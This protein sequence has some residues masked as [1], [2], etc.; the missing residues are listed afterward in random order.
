MTFALE[1]CLHEVVFEGDAA[2][3]IQ[4]SKSSLT[5]HSS[6][7]HITN[8]ISHKSS[9]LSYYDFCYINRLMFAICYF[10]KFPSWTSRLV[11]QKKNTYIYIYIKF[12]SLYLYSNQII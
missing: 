6:F 1:L 4:A 10:N 11:S 7:G 5:E 9:Q 8:D 12:N 2:I 3:V